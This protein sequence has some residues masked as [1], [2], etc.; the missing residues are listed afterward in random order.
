MISLEELKKEIAGYQQLE[1]ITQAVEQS[2]ASYIVKVRNQILAN[3]PFF[4]EAWSCYDLY[5][6]IVYKTKRKKPEGSQVIVLI[7][8]NQGLY[9]LL[10]TQVLQ[11]IVMQHQKQKADLIIVGKKG[12]A[13][14]GLL[15]ANMKFYDLQDDF[16]YEQLEPTIEQVCKYSG[17]RIVYPKYY[18]A[19]EQKIE[20]KNLADDDD[21]S[22]KADAPNAEDIN[23]L[24]LKRYVLDPD[25]LTFEQYFD[26]AVIGLILFRYF[27]ESML[28]YKAAQMTAMRRAHD[29]AHKELLLAKFS[30]SRNHREM[31]D[32]SLRELNAARNLIENE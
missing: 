16:S 28:A 9:G 7:T 5:K 21:D 22:N 27:T 32:G 31:V 6:K 1:G 30:Y 15:S 23:L 24:N 3:R 14:A 29:N 17:I 10:L 20:V 26:K 4:E 19:F 18:S 12:R 11:E 2:S 25:Q 8:P 13:I